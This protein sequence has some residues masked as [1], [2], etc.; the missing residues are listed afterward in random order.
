MLFRAIIAALSLLFLF[1]AERNSAPIKAKEQALTQWRQLTS[2]NATPPN[3]FVRKNE[4]RLSFAQDDKIVVFKA[5]W[6]VDRVPTDK[7]KIGVGKRSEEHTSE[8]QS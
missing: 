8:L 1:S 6:K 3:L 4:V 2:T 5:A 7:Y